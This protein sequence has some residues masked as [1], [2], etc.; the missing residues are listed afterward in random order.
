VPERFEL[1]TL[2][3]ELLAGT[4]AAV[5]LIASL[6]P[7][8]PAAT[9]RRD[10]LVAAMRA[11]ERHED[12]LLGRLESGLLHLGVAVLSRAPHR[13]PT[14]LCTFGDR[15]PAEVVDALAEVGIA[16][17]AGH[18]YALEASRW[19][20]LGDQGGLRAGL[21]PYTDEADVDRLLDALAEVLG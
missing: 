17:G 11:V 13:T 1:G 5:D 12:A 15:R 2:P 19:L 21:S 10:R 3:Y 14:L 18:F 7:V 8:P 20:G 4:A 6:A 9:G 16:T